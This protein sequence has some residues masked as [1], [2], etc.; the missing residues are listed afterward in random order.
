MYYKLTIYQNFDPIQPLEFEAKS[1][2]TLRLNLTKYVKR[3]R[4]PAATCDGWTIGDAKLIQP[5][6]DYADAGW[7]RASIAYIESYQDWTLETVHAPDFDNQPYHK[8]VDDGLEF[9]DALARFIDLAMEWSLM[10]YYS[11]H[12]GTRQ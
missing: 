5:G 9:E 8:D 2:E 10:T 4:Y 11:T 1:I 3:V 12:K 6:E 7:W